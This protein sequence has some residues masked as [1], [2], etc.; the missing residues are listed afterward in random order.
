M[1]VLQ[2]KAWVQ[3]EVLTVQTKRDSITVMIFATGSKAVTKRACL[4][5]TLIWEDGRFKPL[6]GG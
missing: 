3:A 4:R 6:Q 2:K 5:R 1:E